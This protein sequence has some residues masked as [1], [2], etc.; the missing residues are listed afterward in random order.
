V[1]F[2]KKTFSK[3]DPEDFQYVFCLTVKTLP[4]GTKGPKGTTLQI[5][6]F[7]KVDQREKMEKDPEKDQ[8]CKGLQKCSNFQRKHG[9]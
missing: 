6:G 7:K 3:R 1:S 2:E 8:F 9:L 5:G 4:K